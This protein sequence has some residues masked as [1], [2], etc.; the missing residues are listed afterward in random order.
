MR[1]KDSK[2]V[3]QALILINWFFQDEFLFEKV[4]MSLADIL[5]RKDDRYIALGWCILVRRLVEY[6]SLADQYP[7]NGKGI[8]SF[9]LLSPCIHRSAIHLC[10]HED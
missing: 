8:D 7:L 2:Q 3:V 6:E 10:F 5:S 4:S 1:S 9:S